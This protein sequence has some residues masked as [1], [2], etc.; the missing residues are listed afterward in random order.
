MTTKL[1]NKFDKAGYFL[2]GGYGD[3]GCGCEVILGSIING[4][5]YCLKCRE[6]M[7]EKAR[8]AHRV[9]IDLPDGLENSGAESSRAS[10]SE[11][12]VGSAEGQSSAPLDMRTLNK[13]GQR[14]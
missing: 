8:P 5:V 3:K 4:V 2:C 1:K 11:S 6:Q 12:S 13:G 14:K 9:F 10:L 7:G